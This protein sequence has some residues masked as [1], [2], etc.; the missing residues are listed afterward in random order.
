MRVD[1]NT[2]TITRE[3]MMTKKVYFEQKT[4]SSDVDSIKWTNVE[5][6]G[7]YYRK[8]ERQDS[9]PINLLQ[10]KWYMGGINA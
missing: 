8:L 10:Q 6:T 9:N 2:T 4:R 1:I 5:L 3:N 7:I